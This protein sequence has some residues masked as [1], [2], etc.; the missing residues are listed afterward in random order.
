MTGNAPN[1]NLDELRN[2]FFHDEVNLKERYVLTGTRLWHCRLTHTHRRVYRQVRIL[3]LW[4]G[5][6]STLLWYHNYR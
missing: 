5:E 6:D 2:N 3:L 1:S 4:Q